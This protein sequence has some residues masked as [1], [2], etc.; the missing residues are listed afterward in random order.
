MDLT[1]MAHG[2]IFGGFKKT[3]FYLTSGKD[4]DLKRKKITFHDQSSPNNPYGAP[5]RPLGFSHSARTAMACCRDHH[6]VSG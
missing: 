6:T 1:H 3:P 4:H 5:S 2:A